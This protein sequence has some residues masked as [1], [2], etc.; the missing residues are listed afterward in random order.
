MVLCSPNLVPL[1]TILHI[2]ACFFIGDRY[3]HSAVPLRRGGGSRPCVRGGRVQ[4]GAARAHRRRVRPHQGQVGLGR[5]HGRKVSFS[6][7]KP[8]IPFFSTSCD[9]VLS[10]AR[11]STLG[12]AVLNDKIYAVGG[13]DGSTGLNSAEVNSKL[14][15]S[16]HCL[17]KG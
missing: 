8:L 7:S 17:L 13:F 3:G 5:Q 14:N 6:I 12:V 16:V 2:N 1:L 9:I 11:R 10:F 4:R 15:T